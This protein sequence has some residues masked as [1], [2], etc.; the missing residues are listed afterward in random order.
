MR[1]LRDES[2]NRRIGSTALLDRMLDRAR[3][4]PPSD[5]ALV[6]ASAR[7][8]LSFHQMAKIMSVPTA[9]LTRRLH[10]I[11]ARL[12]DPVSV[13]LTDFGKVLRPEYRQ[14]GIE[15]FLHGRSM[16]KLAEKH[17]MKRR[18]VAAILQFVRG[19]ARGIAD[20]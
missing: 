18:E 19:W 5:L 12:H 13:A 15:Y 9:T 8:T 16:N 4:L 6:Q 10:R 7:N 20:H 11:G 3:F 1:Q 17:R 2:E 14:L